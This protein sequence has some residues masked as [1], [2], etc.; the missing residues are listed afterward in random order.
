MVSAGLRGERRGADYEDTNG[1]A[2]SPEETMFGGSLSV[3][4]ALALGTV[5]SRLARGYKAGGFNI[6][7]DVPEESRTFDTETLDS[8]ELGWRGANA[9]ATRVARSAPRPLK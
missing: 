6:G 3:R 2:F 7:A 9:A 4:H 5:Y 1:A 8:F